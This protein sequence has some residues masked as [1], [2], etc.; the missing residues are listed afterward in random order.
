M[1][2]LY[3]LLTIYKYLSF[4]SQLTNC[5]C[6]LAASPRTGPRPRV[7][8]SVSLR[9]THSVSSRRE[10]SSAFQCSEFDSKRFLQRVRE[11]ERGVWVRS[12][13]QIR[14]INVVII[15]NLICTLQHTELGGVAGAA[16][17]DYQRAARSAQ[18]PQN[19]SDNLSTSAKGMP[20]PARTLP[21]P[22]FSVTQPF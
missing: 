2:F 21:P 10:R 1:K 3:V 16:C 17:V 9:M 13:P 6:R 22:S 19:V 7:L 8:S 18:R 11:R 4:Q 5:F 12:M 15:L 14:N 20:L